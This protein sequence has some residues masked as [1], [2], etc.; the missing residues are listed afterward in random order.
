MKLFFEEDRLLLSCGTYHLTL[1]LSNFERAIQYI[2]NV[3]TFNISDVADP[4]LDE[5]I[6]RTSE[7]GVV[8]NPMKTSINILS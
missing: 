5:S 3:A 8:L 7:V 6:I 4:S 1:G 2:E